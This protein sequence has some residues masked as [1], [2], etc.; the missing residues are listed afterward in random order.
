[1]NENLLDEMQVCIFMCDNNILLG[2]KWNTQ[3]FEKYNFFLKK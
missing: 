2:E 3:I 1:M